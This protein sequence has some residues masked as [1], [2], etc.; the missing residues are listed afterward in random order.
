MVFPWSL[1]GLYMT[2]MVGGW[3]PYLTLVDNRFGGET[4]SGASRPP[5]GV[6]SEWTN[7]Q[8]R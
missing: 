1:G 4:S 2:G 5:A 6:V 3:I 8:L 7:L